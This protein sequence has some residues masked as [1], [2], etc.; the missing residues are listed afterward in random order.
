M[1][2]P[3]RLLGVDDDRHHRQRVD[4][5]VVGEDLSRSTSAGVD[6]GLL[7]DDLGEALEDLLS[8]CAMVCSFGDSAFRWSGW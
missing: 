4:V 6:A 3:N 8:L 2:T 7:V 5:E 1:R